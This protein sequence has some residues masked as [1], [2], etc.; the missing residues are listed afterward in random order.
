MK[1]TNQLL[2]EYGTTIFTTMSALSTEFNAINLGQG[3]P[4]VNGPDDILEEAVRAIKYES[5]Q[6]PSMMG[7]KELREATA[8]HSKSFY[9]IDID[10]E[11]QTIITAGATEAIASS[12]FGLINPGDEVIMIEPLYDCYLPLVRRAGGIPKL[13]R[14]DPPNWQLPYE[15]LEAIFSPKTKLIILNSPTNPAA[16]VYKLQELEFIA[17]LI[18]KY[19][20]Y[21]ICDEVYEHLT[22]D[23]ASHIPLMTLP[24]MHERCIRISSAGKTFSM[25]G[26][27]IGY[28]IGA[29][30]LIEAASKAHQFLTFTAPPNLQYAVALGLK[31]EK[32]YFFNLGK[33][34]KLKRDLLTNG[35]E[36]IGFNVL[37]SEG[38]YFLVA[39][40]SPL[41]DFGR[42]IEFCKTLIKDAGVG[43]VP[44]SAFYQKGVNDRLNN[45]IRFCYCKKSD[46]LDTAINRLEKYFA[47]N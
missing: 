24:G 8:Q 27:K 40:Y 14:I 32:E 42:D 45:F 46:T 29:P 19:D 33:D 39:D 16:K 38:T 7:I 23:G 30:K 41:G 21:A 28:S 22:Y 6:Y 25:T 17:A 26:W 9:D 36:R 1:K 11:S 34:M 31:N 18:E 20:A 2:G 44:F 35:L 13:I 37:R 4:D 3:F 12:L 15:K 5:N 43:A 10:W 47:A